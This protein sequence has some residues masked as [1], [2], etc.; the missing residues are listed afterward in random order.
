MDNYE[1]IKSMKREE[2]ADLL[3][4]LLESAVIIDRRKQFRNVMKWLEEDVEVIGEIDLEE[5]GY[6]LDD[7]GSSL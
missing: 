7:N 1:A 6:K 4:R 2:L 3:V 5:Y